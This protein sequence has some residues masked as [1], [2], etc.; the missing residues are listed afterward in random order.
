MLI[1]LIPVKSLTTVKHR[2]APVLAPAQR[3]ALV[4]AMLE[5]L[6]DACAAVAAI[7]RIVVVSRDTAVQALAAAHA[8]DAWAE[9]AGSGLNG[10][11]NWAT[12]RAVGQGATA[13]LVITG[14][15]PLTQAAEVARVLDAV[16]G[17][18]I[19]YVPSEDGTGTNAVFRR[20]AGL[21]P[22][23]FGPG[24]LARHRGLAN[25]AGVAPVIV[26]CPS[27]A[28]DID[29]PDDLAR[30]AATDAPRR[31]VAHARPWLSSVHA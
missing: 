25:A 5:D 1:T 14:D 6:L 15:C 9:P 28:L 12:D 10:A 11:V 13:T 19:A 29:T 23:A 31:S 24:S 2:L 21:I 18:G 22:I 16:G 17:A 8:V 7:D 20:P 27:I 30:L 4:G 3:R 26:S